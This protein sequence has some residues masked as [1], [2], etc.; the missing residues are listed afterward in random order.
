MENQVGSIHFDAQNL[1]YMED[2]DESEH[3]DDKQQDNE[4]NL[5]STIFKIP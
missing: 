1:M 2:E 5:N 3:D 4:V